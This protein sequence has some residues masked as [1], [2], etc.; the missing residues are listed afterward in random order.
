[1]KEVCGS[2]SESQ[3]GTEKKGRVHIIRKRGEGG[4]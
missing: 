3:M 2:L 1:M 4:R